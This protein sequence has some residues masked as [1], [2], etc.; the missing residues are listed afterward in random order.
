[1]HD[2]INGILTDALHAAAVLLAGMIVAAIGS[3]MKKKGIEMTQAQH[4][5]LTKVVEEGIHYAEEKVANGSAVA[6][7]KHDLAR[8]YVVERTG[9]ADVVASD[10]IHAALPRLN[11]GATE[12]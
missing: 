2:W 10:A 12:A 4:D 8:D 7:S 3:W 6:D 1:M 11:L 9:V 5:F